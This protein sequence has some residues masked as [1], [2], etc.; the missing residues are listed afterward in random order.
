MGPRSNRENE[1]ET[2][3]PAPHVERS[4]FGAC[5]QQA[6]CIRQADSSPVAPQSKAMQEGETPDAAEFASESTQWLFCP[7]CGTPTDDAHTTAPCPG[8]GFRPCPSC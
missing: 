5:V 6:T 1:V 3:E 4:D 8:C 2:V 7:R